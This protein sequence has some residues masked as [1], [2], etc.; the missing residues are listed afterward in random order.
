[1]DSWRRSRVV[2]AVAIS[3]YLIVQVTIPITRLNDTEG[4]TR[5][6]WHMFSGAKG[7][8]EFVV[9]TVDGNERVNLGDYMARIRVDVDLTGLPALLCD[10]V[11]GARVVIWDER[12]FRC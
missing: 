7:I 4:G 9:E 6:G 2:A 12:E 3:L 1:M 5:F 8:P 11:P 10:N